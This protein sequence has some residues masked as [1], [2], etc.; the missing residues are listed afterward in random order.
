MSEP[1]F[2]DQPEPAASGLAPDRAPDRA[3]GPDPD[4]SAVE[5]SD[6]VME[7]SAQS[8]AP[9]LPADPQPAPSRP[10][11][12]RFRRWRSTRPFWGGLLV[13]L[14]GIEIAITEIA[15]L[16]VILHIGLYGLA[17]YLLPLILVLCGLLLLFN[18]QQR[19]FYSVLSVVL[20]L[21]TWLTSNLG[22]FI[23]GMLLGII[24]GSL[25]FGWSPGHERPS[26]KE[27]AALRERERRESPITTMHGDLTS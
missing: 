9:D 24:G 19:T 5:S 20:A 22:G 21:G 2:P 4:W 15:P 10:R 11:G 13:A 12:G 27:R 26:R 6:P 7:Q 14:G 8:P 16:P 25:A 3:P 18:P 1:G 23:A 17:G